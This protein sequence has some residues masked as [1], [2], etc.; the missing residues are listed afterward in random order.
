MTRKATHIILMLLMIFSLSAESQQLMLYPDL[1]IA[2][3][4]D[5]CWLQM[6][7]AFWAKDLAPN[8]KMVIM[9]VRRMRCTCVSPSQ[10]SGW[11]A[12]M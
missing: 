2:R 4:G 1:K 7:V 12:V 11:T 6:P 9:P 5:D 3:I 10:A 8:Q